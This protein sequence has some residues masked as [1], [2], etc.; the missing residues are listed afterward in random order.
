MANH[1][2]I[3]GAGVFFSSRLQW[4]P[5]PDGSGHLIDPA[6]VELLVP[7]YL[8]S[9]RLS[10]SPGAS[11]QFKTSIADTGSGS[12][13]GPQMTSIWEGFS[14]AITLAAGGL[15]ITLPGPTHPDNAGSDSTEPYSWNIP[16]NRQPDLST[17][18]TAYDA[19]TDV[20]KAATTLTLDDG[21]VPPVI[22]SGQSLDLELDVSEATITAEIPA[23]PLVLSDSDDTGL[24]VDCKALLV[25]SADGTA[26]NNFYADS[27]RGGSDAPLDGELGLGADETVISRFRRFDATSLNLNDNDNPA[28]LDIGAYFEAGGDG[29]DLTIYLQT[30]DAGE[31]SFDVASQLTLSGA[32]FARFNLPAAAQTL[33]D[34]L[35]NGDRWIF[36]L[37]RPESTAEPVSLSGQSLNLELD[38]AQAS[39]VATSAGAVALQGQALGLDLDIARANV[40]VTS[41]ID[42][43]LQGQALGIELDVSRANVSAATAG[44]VTLQGQA[45]GLELDV[46]RANVSARLPRQGAPMV[47]QTR[48]RL[49]RLEA[50]LDLLFRT[51]AIAE[52]AQRIS[53]ETY[54]DRDSAIAARDTFV[55][56]LDDIAGQLDTQTFTAMRALRADVTAHIS[57]VAG[58]LPQ[59]VT[60]TPA[61]IIPSLVVSY[62]VYGN[63]DQADNIAGRNRLP[64]PGF[65]PARP[66]E[67]TGLPT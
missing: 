26:G 13:F 19:L 43:V 45:L 55:D 9:F 65:V 14:G 29:D 34:N 2:L 47:A 18:A 56:L 33:L 1:T 67:I 32:N 35:A 21:V 12:G 46:S 3:I 40:V 38:V 48:V 6:L 66:I 51:A 22:L 39:V 28:A 23:P 25:A 53:E 30:A 63:L 10:Y 52:L 59:V 11:S 4:T 62:A 5:F 7:I 31:V 8:R 58:D 36:K 54:L 42:V 44:V 64:R 50:D 60:A 57:R 17:F 49:G 27:D 61:A 41:V 37:A 24:E 15:S 16:T 20:E